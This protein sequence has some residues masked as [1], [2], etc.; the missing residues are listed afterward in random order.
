MRGLCNHAAWAATRQYERTYGD[1][2]VGTISLSRGYLDSEEFP[3]PKEVLSL[4]DF[5]R[6]PLPGY[7]ERSGNRDIRECLAG[8]ESNWTGCDYKPD[9]VALVDG[10]LRGLQVSLAALADAHPRRTEV[11]APLP[12]Y[13]D[14]VKEAYRCGD[15]RTIDLAEESGYLATPEALRSATSSSTLAVVLANPS[16]PIGRY[17][18]EG[19]LAQIVELAERRGFFL[20]LDETGDNF[21]RDEAASQ[22]A[23]QGA[24]LRSNHVI[25]VR[26]FSKEFGLAG[27]RLGYIVSTADIFDHVLQAASGNAP[28]VLNRVI[29]TL[30]YADASEELQEALHATRMKMVRCGDEFLAELGE[31]KAL[32]VFPPEAGYNVLCQANLGVDT[33][34]LTKR[35]MRDY[36]VSVYPGEAMGFSSRPNFFRLSFANTRLRNQEGLRR[37]KAGLKSIA[38]VRHSSS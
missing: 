31:I 19:D 12:C 36:K 24:A 35:L 27:F 33:M 2:P 7:Q 1:R 13:G 8:F 29:P 6:Q 37:L 23:R 38:S 34:E 9:H 3:L 25:R 10:A 4:L 30:V 26:S 28:T 32:R 14:I 5:S 22:R 15:L 11:L 16:N 18:P 20:I 21:V 17:I